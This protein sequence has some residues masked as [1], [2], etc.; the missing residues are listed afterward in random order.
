M[1]FQL[2]SIKFIPLKT[3]SFQSQMVPT[4]IPI[5][6]STSSNLIRK[7]FF[8]INFQLFESLF[9]NIHHISDKLEIPQ[10]IKEKNPSNSNKRIILQNIKVYCKKKLERNPIKLQFQIGRQIEC[11]R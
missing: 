3:S 2:N 5:R 8:I 1:E 9:I 7:L 10:K 4:K 11:R 6:P